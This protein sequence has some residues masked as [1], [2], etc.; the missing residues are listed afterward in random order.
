MFVFYSGPTDAHG[1]ELYYGWLPGSEM[2]G[3]SSWAFLEAPPN[4]EPAFDG[5]FKWVFGANWDWT[6]FNFTR[7]M[8]KVNAALAPSVNG[9]TKGDLTAFRARGGKLVI[10]QG[11]ADDLVAP[12][13][14]LFFYQ[15]QEKEFGAAQTQD[16]ARLFFAPGVAHCGGGDGPN[17]FNAFNAA[18]GATGRLRDNGPE[19]DIFSAMTDWVEDGVAPSRIIATKYVEDTP[20]KGIALRRPLCA[21]P[22]K[23]WY[24]GGETRD[25]RNFTCAAQSPKH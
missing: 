3:R 4:H 17:A 11:L 9:A 14:T 25:P 7:D 18:N 13:Q 22:Q 15:K 16:F 23:A 5:L 2:S 6:R 10:Y 12:T 19:Q 8:P 20:A 21:W 24:T 1:R